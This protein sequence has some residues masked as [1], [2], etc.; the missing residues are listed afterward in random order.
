[1]P[2]SSFFIG[3][4]VFRGIHF[5]CSWRFFFLFH[6]PLS[7]SCDNNDDEEEKGGF[8]GDGGGAGVVVMNMMVAV[9]FFLNN[10]ARWKRWPIDGLEAKIDTQ[11]KCLICN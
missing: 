3:S 1:M 7:N 2:C 9:I 8:G 6:F 11:I 10:R 5:P 4:L